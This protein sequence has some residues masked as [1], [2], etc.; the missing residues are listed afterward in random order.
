MGSL[1]PNQKRLMDPLLLLRRQVKQ[2]NPSISL[3]DNDGREVKDLSQC[4]Y[5][6]VGNFI[7][8]RDQPTNFRSKRGA[9]DFYALDAVWFMHCKRDSGYG[10][11]MQEARR[12]GIGAVSL[13]DRKDLVRYLEEEVRPEDCPFVDT[14]APL[15]APRRS[16][17]A[18]EEEEEEGEE[19][20]LQDAV[21]VS[22]IS[23]SKGL[24]MTAKEAR[25]RDASLT[26][27]KD[28]SKVLELAK[29]VYKSLD[30]ANTNSTAAKPLP[31][32]PQQQQQPVS[33]IEQIASANRPV[34]SQRLEPEPVMERQ[35]NYI[36][37]IIVPAAP[38]ATLTMHNVASFLVDG[39]YITPSEAKSKGKAKE[40]SLLIEHKFPNASK[41]IKLQI[42]DNPV[43]LTLEDWRRVV[44]VFV[45][46]SAWQ[47][48]GWKWETPVELFQHVMGYSLEFDDAPADIKVATWNVRQ[49]TV[50]RS[51][52]HGD[53]TALFQFWTSLEEFLRRKQLLSN[54]IKSKIY[55]DM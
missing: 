22:D 50:S 24:S 38:T 27:S 37:I 4:V 2:A 6:K 32:P 13:V 25:A 5:M 9:G 14:T 15:P 53:A 44:A 39:N 3:H 51:R 42:I 7:L 21:M 23:A 49:L 46:G 30:S 34:S 41:P 18:G 45:Q 10:E 16:F 19:E 36:P 26:S 28:F 12:M 35:K 1:R 55:N 47:F 33:L 29:E 48:K 31:P 54:K 40:N 8:P 11:Y 52:R 20:Q 43:R 17:A